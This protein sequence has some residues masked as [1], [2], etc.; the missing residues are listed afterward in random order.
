MSNVIKLLKDGKEVGRLLGSM[1]QKLVK[2]HPNDPL[3]NVYEDDMKATI[4]AAK[5]RLP[6]IEFDSVEA[7]DEQAEAEKQEAATKEAQEKQRDY[8]E[9]KEGKTV[10]K[11]AAEAAERRAGF[12]EELD[13]LKKEVTELKELVGKLAAAGLGN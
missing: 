3:K 4:A 2:E 7:V 11:K 1:H 6:H 5:K 8:L 9:S 10:L 13:D 12:A